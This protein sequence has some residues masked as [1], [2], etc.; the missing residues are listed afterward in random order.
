M[1]PNSVERLAGVLV[2]YSTGVRKGD[3]VCIDTA[4]AAAPLVR[5]IWRRV[6]EAGGHPHLRLD[7]DGAPSFSFGKEATSSWSGSA[8]SVVRRWS[9]PTCGSPSRRM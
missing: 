4:P 8:P 2:D 9:V 6:L 1:A 7:V 5:E 3:L